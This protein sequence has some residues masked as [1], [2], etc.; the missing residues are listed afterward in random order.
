MGGGVSSVQGEVNGFLQ[1]KVD[2]IVLEKKGSFEASL[3]REIIPA[4]N[5]D[6]R[7]AL[8]AEPL[9]AVVSADEVSPPRSTVRRPS[10][11]SHSSSI[12]SLAMSHHARKNSVESLLSSS[13]VGGNSSRHFLFES[14]RKPSLHLHLKLPMQDELDW[15]PVDEE[16]LDEDHGQSPL[17][18]PL[19]KPSYL[20]TKSG[21]MLIDG[22]SPG[23]GA[24]GL[25]MFDENK[26]ASTEYFH[27]IPMHERLVMLSKLGSGATSTV[28][29]AFDIEDMRVFFDFIGLF[30]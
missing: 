6:N 10:L 23:I 21:T 19:A 2:Q 4:D 28:F 29:K 5:K 15:I 3:P 7:G 11:Q 1:R 12:R 16:G 13:S 20:F 17:K 18:A 26:R 27:K 24:R 30:F 22:I 8:A 9:H 25:K 14:R